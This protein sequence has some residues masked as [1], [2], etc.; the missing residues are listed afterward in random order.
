M[1]KNV[2]YCFVI[3][4]LTSGCTVTSYDGN[5]YF[6]E[7][8]QYKEANFKYVTTIYGTSTAI[9]NVLGLDK[10]S[11]PEGMA[12]TAKKDMY[13]NYTF[14][15]NQIITNISTETVFSYLTFFNMFP[16]GN[17]TYTA[18]V[19]A[20]V[21]EFSN[22]GIY[23]S[24]N[25]T[26]NSS[27]NFDETSI[28]KTINSPENLDETSK[29]KTN[30]SPENLGENVIQKLEKIK[31]TD[32]KINYVNNIHQGSHIYPDQIFSDK[33]RYSIGDTIN[34]GF[35]QNNAVIV[36]F[37]LERDLPGF[38]EI[39]IRMLKNNKI[40]TTSVPFISKD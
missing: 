6:P 12:A 38:H 17:Y 39:K 40:K 19:S 23:S 9:W 15:P 34:I 13:S 22:N 24:K 26:N 2:I 7:N 21:Y 30:N 25:K 14:E 36:G 4:L 31:N 33:F 11:L 8:S 10:K 1:I 18:I 27:E 5:Y 32:V 35:N 29:N 37:I 20:D 3:I 28:N 16:L